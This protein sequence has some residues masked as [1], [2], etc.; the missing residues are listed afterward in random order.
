M[1]FEACYV[2]CSQVE[3]LECALIEVLDIMTRSK[4]LSSDR[5]S[6]LPLGQSGEE[7]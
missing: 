1:D 2:S 4:A 3:L 7:G 5:P 6:G